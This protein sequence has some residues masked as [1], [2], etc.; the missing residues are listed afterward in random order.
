MSNQNNYRASEGALGRSQRFGM[1]DIDNYTALYIDKAIRE[2]DRK[3]AIEKINMLK[4]IEQLEN[5]YKIKLA[6]LEKQIEELR[7]LIV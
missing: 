4:H 5:Q 1:R 7:S 3:F 6:S 2:Y